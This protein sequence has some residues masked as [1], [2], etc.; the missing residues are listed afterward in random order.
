M[1]LRWGAD[2]LPRPYIPFS[3]TYVYL[4]L[5]DKT[6]SARFPMTSFKLAIPHRFRKSP[7]VQISSAHTALLQQQAGSPPD[8]IWHGADRQ[9]DWCLPTTQDVPGISTS[10][11]KAV[12]LLSLS[13]TALRWWLPCTANVHQ[14]ALIFIGTRS[15]QMYNAGCCRILST[16]TRDKKCLQKVGNLIIFL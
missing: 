15:L 9:H 12:P 2:G 16:W 6:Q 8:N 10:A 11:E 13:Y 3:S 4:M 1:G 5:S 14:A 7:P